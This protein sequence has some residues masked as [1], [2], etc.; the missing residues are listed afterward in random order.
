MC[1][2][3]PDISP[4]SRVGGRLEPCSNRLD[5]QGNRISDLGEELCEVGVL[6]TGPF[7]FDTQGALGGFLR[8]E[9]KGHMAQDGEVMWALIEAISGIVLIHNHVQCRLF[10]TA[11]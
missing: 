5:G 10:S 6:P 3:D 8:Q 1:A 2:R 11:Q 4:T 9:I 7:D